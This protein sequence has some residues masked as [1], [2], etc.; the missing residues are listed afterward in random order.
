VNSWAAIKPF[1]HHGWNM[2][3]SGVLEIDSWWFGVSVTKLF[4]AISGTSASFISPPI[5][6]KGLNMQA[7]LVQDDAG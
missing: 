4:P 3:V 2:R 1:T 7:G 6:L 5:K